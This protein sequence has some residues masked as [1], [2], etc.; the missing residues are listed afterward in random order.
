[1]K[2]LIIH[3]WGGSDFPHWQ[4]W[5]A[6]EVAKDYGCV[7]FFRFSDVDSPILDIWESELLEHLDDFK[8]DIVVCHSLANTLWFHLCNGEKIKERVK[9]L[10][11]VAPPSLECKIEE[12]KTFFPLN[13]PKELFA[14]KSLLIT[15][16]N[17][18]Y[19]NVDD[20]NKLQKELGVEM[21]MLENAGHINTDS[22]FGEWPWMLENIKKDMRDG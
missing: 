13:A 22:G 15:S 2:V 21:K 18:P 20:A 3:G 10:Y 6:S 7:S 1:M 8:P 12:L 11:L 16:T 14:N 19:L 17:D 9:K 4:S 5:L